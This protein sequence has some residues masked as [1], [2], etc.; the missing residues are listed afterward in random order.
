MRLD[1]EIIHVGMEKLLNL[2]FSISQYVKQS[3]AKFIGMSLHWHF[4]SYDTIEV[5]RAIKKENPD[6]YIV[7][8]GY[9]A[10]PLRRG[11]T[12]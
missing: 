4:Q 3:G 8:G 9:T 12:G 6:T 11:N 1:T 2:K 5:A 10:S 7:L